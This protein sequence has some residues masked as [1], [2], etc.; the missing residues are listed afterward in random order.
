[1]N[2]EELRSSRPV[3]RSSAEKTISISSS[4]CRT[5]TPPVRGRVIVI[6]YHIVP[7]AVVKSNGPDRKGECR[8]YKL[9]QEKPAQ[10][11]DDQKKAF[12]ISNEYR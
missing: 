8:L 2:I 10:P 3:V 7:V 6:S 4:S 12:E 9:M 5:K 1:M 11:I